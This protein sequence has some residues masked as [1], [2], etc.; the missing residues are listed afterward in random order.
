[1][2]YRILLVVL[3]AVITSCERASVP[4]NGWVPEVVSLSSESGMTDAELTAVLKN[5]PSG[6][7]EY[8]FYYRVTGSESYSR[9]SASY[10]A[11][12]FTATLSGLKPLTEYE[13]MA[14]VSN[15]RSE[16]CSKIARFCT[17]ESYEFI[18]IGAKPE[19]ESATLAATLKNTPVKAKGVGF[20]YG[21]SEE[22]MK[23]C[24]A[25]AVDNVISLEIVSLSPQTQ[26]FFKAYILTEKG[27]VCSVTSSFTTTF[28]DVT[29]NAE[30]SGVSATPGERM[31]DI[32][33]YVSD[34]G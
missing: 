12:T 31:A 20:Y 28:K 24:P 25:E 1:M 11:G 5:E 6:V 16:I 9:T 7:Y 32:E 3:S 23:P 2:T 26:Y 8:G 21:L 30:I 15:G 34:P 17:D 22:N 27:Y 10:D 19:A 29:F 4:E 33:A 13:V 18:S 14:Y